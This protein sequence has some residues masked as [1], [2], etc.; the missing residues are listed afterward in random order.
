[1]MIEIRNTDFSRS[2]ENG[3]TTSWE[4]IS[5]RRGPQLFFTDNWMEAKA[6]ALLY[7]WK[8]SSPITSATAVIHFYR[9]HC[10]VEGK[11]VINERL[12]EGGARND[13]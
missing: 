9:N 4:R 13:K 10:Q 11:K 12:R 6:T 1:M 3:I 2:E 7:K 5:H 8:P